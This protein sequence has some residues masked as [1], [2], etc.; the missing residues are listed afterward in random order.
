M[1]RTEGR[2]ESVDAILEALFHALDWLEV[3]AR[4]SSAPPQAKGH[5]VRTLPQPDSGRHLASALRHHSG[6]VSRASHG[7]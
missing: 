7:V 4:A 2:E 1:A 5:N 3:V 6:A